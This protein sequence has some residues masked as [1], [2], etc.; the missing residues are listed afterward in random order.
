MTFSLHYTFS[1]VEFDRWN[2]DSINY[3]HVEETVAFIQ[4]LTNERSTESFRYGFAMHLTR[5]LTV[6][7]N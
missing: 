6:G 1:H 3:E 5:N 2:I 4:S 7:V